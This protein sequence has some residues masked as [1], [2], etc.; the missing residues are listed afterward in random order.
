MNTTEM[1]LRVPWAGRR[2]LH[3]KAALRESL[4]KITIPDLNMYP[5]LPPDL[6]RA[7]LRLWTLLIGRSATDP[8]QLFGMMRFAERVALVRYGAQCPPDTAAVELGAHAGISTCFLS[9]GLM[10]AG[11][12]S[13]WAVDTFVGSTTVEIDKASY[14]RT[15]QAAGGSVLPWFRRHVDMFDL[16]GFAIEQVGL[17]TEVAKRW[18]GDPIGLLF[19]DA[20]H[21]YESCRADFEA[22]QPWLTDNALVLF[23]DHEPAYP[24]IIQAVEEF[25]QAGLLETL[26]TVCT[27]RVCRYH[28]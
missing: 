20:D 2:M 12:T 1:L 18:T 26:E 5:D 22:W 11:A 10:R 16:R 8:D 28:K 6:H 7:V 9:A 14:A 15:T 3:A 13:L 17:T 4:G 24:G 23:H 19:V 25:H 27:L 21:S